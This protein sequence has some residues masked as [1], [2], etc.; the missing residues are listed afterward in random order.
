[1]NQFPVIDSAIFPAQDS[2]ESFRSFF[3][4]RFAV[5][6]LAGNDVKNP[7]AK[8]AINAKLRTQAVEALQLNNV[9]K[10]DRPDPGGETGVLFWRVKNNA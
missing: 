9:E 2:V 7:L 3:S 6:Y 8:A 4:S 10:A 1:V 5:H